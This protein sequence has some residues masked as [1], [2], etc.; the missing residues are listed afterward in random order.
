[1]KKS[2]IRLIIF[3]LLPSFLSLIVL[4][5]VLA[6]PKKQSVWVVHQKNRWGKYVFYYTDN[7]LKIE[8]S[9]NGVLISKAPD[10]DVFVYHKTDKR[11]TQIPLKTWVHKAKGRM[12]L[13]KL[14]LKALK[15]KVANLD[16][17]TYIFSVNSDVDVSGGT[18]A[19]Y[20]SKMVTKFA[21]NTVVTFD[22][23]QKRRNKI[24]V[25]I[26]SCFFE[27]PNAGSVP[28]E[29]YFDLKNGKREY[30]LETLKQNTAKLPSSIFDKP[31][32]LTRTNSPVLSIF[33]GQGI[34]DATEL[35]F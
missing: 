35:L 17:L 12:N 32:G 25:L 1:M 6:A 5:T 20:Q 2:L 15:R 18:N 28:I 13:N 4:P 10:W 23:N 8:G 27:F 24:P 7:A 34:L 11:Y 16:V 14:K 26:W 30:S 31:K 21:K 33:M 3:F 22:A 29:T 9:S 19:M